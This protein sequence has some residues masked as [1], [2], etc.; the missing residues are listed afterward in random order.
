MGWIMIFNFFRLFFFFTLV[1]NSSA[2]IADDPG[3]AFQ[4]A[5]AAI[6]SGLSG[7]VGGT[8][9]NLSNYR[10]NSRIV[11]IRSALARLLMNADPTKP[12]NLEIS[13]DAV[14]CGPRS[15]YAP[16]AVESAYLGVMASTLNK[17]ATPPKITTIGE[18]AGNLFQNYSIAASSGQVSPNSRK[19]VLAIC[20]FDVQNWPS[21]FYGVDIVQ[22]RSKQVE[23]SLAL[24]KVSDAIGIFSDLYQVLISVITPIVANPA[25]AQDASRRNDAIAKFLTQYRGQLETAATDLAGYGSRLARDNRLQAVGQFAE[26]MSAVRALSIDLSKVDS[27]KAAFAKLPD[28]LSLEVRDKT[29]G[30]VVSHVPTDAYVVCYAQAWL[31]VSGAIQDAVTA[32]SAY[33]SL[34]DMSSDQLIA[35]VETVKGN[36]SK[37][38]Q[39]G[40]VDVSQL[41]NATT[42]LVAYGQAVNQASGTANAAKM[43]GDVEVL[44][45]Q[46]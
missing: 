37:V 36:L 34:V 31:Q 20:Q 12:I 33:D 32:A 35:A 19:T 13:N 46:F 42:Q 27:C 17:F 16:I 5:A 22:D 8:Q 11:T 39:Q 1:A 41:L 18:A 29:T 26:K 10:S 7:L 45:K 14:L 44:M 23:T 28:S 25:A 9:Q 43:K 40:K 4:P 38:N 15:S 24:D 3:P 2:A 21:K 30:V 6:A